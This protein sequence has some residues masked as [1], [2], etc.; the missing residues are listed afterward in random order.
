MFDVDVGDGEFGVVDGDHRQA[1]RALEEGSVSGE[2]WRLVR[3]LRLPGALRRGRVGS[4]AQ[5]CLALLGNVRG[6]VLDGCAHR[7]PRALKKGT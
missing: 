3:Q 7:R 4:A 2:V 1:G 5:F 6:A